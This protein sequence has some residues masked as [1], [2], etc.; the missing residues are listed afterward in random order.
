MESGMTGGERKSPTA[1]AIG[2]LSRIRSETVRN[3]LGLPKSGQVYDLGLELNSRIPHNPEFVRFAMSFTHT[4]EGTGALSPFQYSV[5]SVFGALHIGTHIDSFIHVQKEGRI[6]G[7]R[8][9]SESRDDR[10]WTRHGVETVP[11]ILGRAICLDIPG[12]K[13]LGRLPDRYEVTIDDL[14]QELARGGLS[15]QS[16]DIVIVR[17]G[18]IQDFGDEAA[19]QTAEPG[20]GRSAALWLYERGMSV[21]G[22]DTTGTEPLPFDDPAVTTHGAMLVEKGVHLIENLYLEDVARDGVREGL[23]IALP[24]KITGATGSWIR[25]IL[26]V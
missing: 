24:L 7:G 6:Y 5:E 19:F 11:P 3:A 2:A 10:G 13:G 16:G 18:K 1:E 20:M 14:K 26:V 21:L 17:T 23:F 8:L 25:P 15:V 4:P 22:T 12:L 9:A